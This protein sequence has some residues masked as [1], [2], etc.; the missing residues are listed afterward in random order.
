MNS[1]RIYLDHAGTTPLRSE[2]ANVMTETSLRCGFN[3]SSLHFEGRL[4]RA[5]LDDARD[6][7]ARIL[8]A[9]RTEVVFTSGGTESNNLAI[10]GVVQAAAPG[11]RV[12]AS[13]VEHHSVRAALER[14]RERSAAGSPIPVDSNGRVDP[15]EF[16][17]TLGSQPVCASVM[18][19][20]NE[21]G[22][23]QP[24][25]ALAEIARAHRVLLH[26]DAVAAPAWL[27]IDV[28]DLGVDLL[29]LSAHKFG[30]PEG[31]GVLFVREGVPLHPLMLGGGQEA[32]RRAGT[33]NVAGIAG[34]A[35]ALELAAAERASTVARIVALRDRLERGVTAAA[36]GVSVNGAGAL[37]LANLS[38]M[39]FEGVEA[40][41]LLIALDLAGIA[42]SAGS[43][44]TSGT[45]EPSHVLAAMYPGTRGPS[46][47]RFSLGTTTTA[48]EIDR[49]V[50]AIPSL[51]VRLRERRAFVL[52]FE[53]YG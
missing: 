2:V 49:V 46:G 14:L 9:K 37:R 35:L 41:D 31:V 10:F 39:S 42:V 18:Y 34:L 13:A 33:E 28:V 12:V 48:G 16:E 22:T 27:P 19:A 17:R 32:G 30:G 40:G 47:I 36:P 15:Q 8:G 50:A 24:V 52:P 21:V 44:C 29:S 4:A 43:A 1:E 45:L 23:V 25:P 11:A 38:N 3:A 7:V 51:L 5:A 53:G 26:A 20:N 6:R